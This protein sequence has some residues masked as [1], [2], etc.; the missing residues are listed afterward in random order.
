MIVGIGTSSA[1]AFVGAYALIVHN[2]Q[3][4]GWGTYWNERSK[5]ALGLAVTIAVAAVL[6]TLFATP[7]PIDDLT[8]LREALGSGPTLLVKRDDAIPF[9]FGGNKVRKLQLVGARAQAE[10]ADTLITCGGVQSNGRARHSKRWPL[11]WGCGAFSSRMGR[12]LHARPQMRCWTRC[13]AQRFATSGPERSGSPRWRRRPKRREPRADARS[14]FRLAPLRRWER[15]ATRS[16]SA[17]LSARRRRRTSSCT[18]RPRAERRP[19]YCRLPDVRAPD[20]RHRHQRR[21]PG[22]GALGARS[23]RF[24]SFDLEL[25]VGRVAGTL[26]DSAI[27]VD[28][29]FVGEG[30]GIPTAASEEAIALCARS[31]ALFVDPTYTAKAMAGLIARIR[32]R[33]L[34]GDRVMFWHTGGQVALFA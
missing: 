9:G 22:A 27:E 19:G 12:R 26:A 4:W 32:S 29:Q 15:P 30:Y 21:R 23:R 6:F 34:S 3:R 16:R 24:C 20:A 31:E 11:V 25:A 2:A 28:N 14:S 13:W 18:R 10:G 7:P 8:R 5:I 17:R 33:T 1:F